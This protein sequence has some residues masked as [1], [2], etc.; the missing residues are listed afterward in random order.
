[1]N[2]GQQGIWLTLGFINSIVFY[3]LS[4]KLL[5]SYLTLCHPVDFSPPGSSSRT[6][7]SQEDMEVIVIKNSGDLCAGR[8]GQNT[9]H[10]VGLWLMQYLIHRQKKITQIM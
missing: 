10:L 9:E 3:T 4:A 8:C 7:L 2:Y 6:N 5:Q 1:M